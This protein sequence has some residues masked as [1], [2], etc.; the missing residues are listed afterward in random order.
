MMDPVLFLSLPL[1][2]GLMLIA[3][4]IV[5]ARSGVQPRGMAVTE[6]QRGIIAQLLQKLRALPDSL[7]ALLYGAGFTRLK[8]GML[9]IV[10]LAIAAACALFAHLAYLIP[11]LTLTAALTAFALPFLW[12]SARGKKRISA[13][14]TLWPELAENLVS[15]LRSG[16]SIPDALASLAPLAAGHREAFENFQRNYQG[17]RSFVT[18]LELLKAELADPVADRILESIRSARELGGAELVEI[19]QGLADAIRAENHLRSELEARQSWLINAARLGAAAPWVVLAL[20]ASRPETAEMYSSE[21]GTLLI[22]GGFVI[23]L[24]AYRMMLSIAKLPQE[25]RW[26]T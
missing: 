13:A 7:A 10:A 24:L 18:A 12:L 6:Q 9:V 25:R 11:A 19:L 16:V 20:L 4:S 22:L 15:A 14:K 5:D 3:F 1:A 21:L 23:T 8:P 26:L 2:L 17:G